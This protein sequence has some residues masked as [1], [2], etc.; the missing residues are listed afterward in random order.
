MST[1]VVIYDNHPIILEGLKHLM[2]NR[3]YAVTCSTSDASEFIYQVEMS[4]PE[5]VI[6][7]PLYLP[8]EYFDKLCRIKRLNSQMKIFVL[9]GADSVFHLIRGHR[10][11]IQGY[12]SKSDELDM[13]DYLLSRLT[14]NRIIITYTMQQR[15]ISKDNDYRIMQSLTNLE[16]QIL[17]ELGAGKSNKVIADELLLSSKTIST[18]KRSIMHKLKTQ[19]LCDVVDFAR[20]NGF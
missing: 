13:V 7:D 8:E 18:Y 12:L 2:A 3:D 9:A 20:R 10:L 5:V 11:E 14:S 19:K 16:L 15:I 17:R 4:R 1:N 6:L